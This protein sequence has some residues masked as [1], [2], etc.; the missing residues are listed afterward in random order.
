[1]AH[2]K[3]GRERGASL[4]VTTTKQ[5]ADLDTYRPT[6]NP[7][8]GGDKATVRSTGVSPLICAAVAPP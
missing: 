4:G 1:M 6:P 7:S 8:P 5:Y 3:D 2:Y